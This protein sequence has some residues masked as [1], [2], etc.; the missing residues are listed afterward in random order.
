MSA[1]T[2]NMYLQS[3]ISGRAQS[4]C[5][6]CAAASTC[7]EDC[8]RPD[9]ELLSEEAWLAFITLTYVIDNTLHRKDA[10][11]KSWNSLCVCGTWQFLFLG[12]VKQCLLS[13]VRNCVVGWF[14]SLCHMPAVVTADLGLDAFLGVWGRTAI[15]ELET[16]NGCQCWL[17]IK[18]LTISEFAEF[19]ST[20]RRDTSFATENI[21]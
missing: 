13:T 3:S 9:D 17:R 7:W 4:W 12:C 21:E 5:C 19:S 11:G 2:P 18:L 1:Y 10:L 15:L 20:D 6:V 16:G 8:R 14:C